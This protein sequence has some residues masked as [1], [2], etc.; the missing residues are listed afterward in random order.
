MVSAVPPAR[1][2]DGAVTCTAAF[3]AI[4]HAALRAEPVLLRGATCPT[5]VPPT[6]AAGKG[7]HSVLF[8][9]NAALR[10]AGHGVIEVVWGTA[11]VSAWLHV[12]RPTAARSRRGACTAVAPGNRRLSGTT[13]SRPW[14]T[15][16]ARTARPRAF[17]QA[18]VCPL[19]TLMRSRRRRRDARRGGRSCVR[20]TAPII[21]ITRWWH[22][23][24]LKPWRPM[25]LG[26]QPTASRAVVAA[27][28]GAAAGGTAAGLGAGVLESEVPD[29]VSVGVTDSELDALLWRLRRL[30][31]LVLAGLSRGRPKHWRRRAR[32]VW[33]I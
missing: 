21:L 22:S 20:G 25:A 32:N 2:Y 9:R 17:A 16:P 1:P 3:S 5:P 23:A 30:G 33:L 15:S 18:N 12:R 6:D 24:G 4:D 26:A 19:G 10:L 29:D 11:P 28:G 14:G 13:R 7:M 31:G 27:G 8:K